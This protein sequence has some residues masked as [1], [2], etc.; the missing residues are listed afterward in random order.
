MFDFILIIL[1]F[2][3]FGSIASYIFIVLK[4]KYYL[5]NN[6]III[7]NQFVS[8]E[9]LDNTDMKE[10]FLN[11]TRLKSGDEIKVRTK[12]EETFICTILGG[13]QREKAIMVITKKND[14]LKFKIE[15]IKQFKIVS[16]Y[17]SFF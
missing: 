4:E 8:Q 14:I 12:E 5:K 9:S 3:F 10:F 1:T 11:G 16:K 2:L 15:S 17:G 13:I 7:D 6:I